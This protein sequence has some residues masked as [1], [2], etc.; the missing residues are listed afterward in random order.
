MQQEFLIMADRAEAIGGKMFIMGGGIDR[1]AFTRV[2]PGP[3]Q[4]NADIALGILTDWTETNSSHIM[5]VRVVSEDGQT[6]WTL[7]GQFEV[8]RPPGAKPAQQFRQLIA[9]RGPIALPDAG[10]YK[11][12]LELDGTVQGPPFRFWLDETSVPAPPQSR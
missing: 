2:Q 8:G 11:V 3:V 6:V 12:E 1:H 5:A 9:I 10:A 4:L 7:E